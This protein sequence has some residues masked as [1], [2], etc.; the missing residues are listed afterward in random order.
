MIEELT[1]KAIR[2]YEHFGKK[3]QLEKFYEEVQEYIVAPTPENKVEEM[4]DM[5][6]V[7]LQIYLKNPGFQNM[8]MGKAD[9][10]EYRIKTNWYE[11]IKNGK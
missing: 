7:L 8:V 11:E 2:I 6:L 4:G 1:Q 10:T 5:F 3:N 9:R